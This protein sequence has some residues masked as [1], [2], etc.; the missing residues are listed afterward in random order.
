ME[1]S[2]LNS[3]GTDPFVSAGIFKAYINIMQQRE[4]NFA[5]LNSFI[6]YGS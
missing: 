6:Q 3:Q 5:K 2:L 4:L 1:I